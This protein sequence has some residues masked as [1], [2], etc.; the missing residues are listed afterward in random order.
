MRHRASSRDAGSDRRLLAAAGIAV[1]LIAIAVYAATWRELPF[2]DAFEVHGVFS[3]SNQLRPGNPVRRAGVEIGKVTGV[4]TGPEGTSVVTMEL[5]DPKH[6]RRNASLAIKP[7]L[8]FEGNFYVDVSAGT[9]A[10]PQ[11]EDGTTIPLERTSVPV[12]VDQVLSTLTEP[13]RS[14]LTGTVAEL[15]TG[16]GGAR[17]M[18]GSDEMR[19]AT[20]EL[21]AA[22]GSVEQTARAVQG[23]A[24]G[25]LHRAVGSTAD[26]TEQLGR[27]PNALADLV[28]DFDRV[29]GA[30]SS[31]TDSLS[32]SVRS[33]D[34]VLRIA[35]A[36]LREI[37][38]AL[39][40]LTRFA[41]D[42][43]PG[44]RAAPAAFDGTTGLLRQL[45]LASQPGE[46]ASFVRDLEPLTANLP[47]LQ[48]PLARGLD[49]L[50]KA[51]QC[52][53]RTILPALNTKL[54]DGPNS[55]DRPVWHDVLHLGAN[56]LGSSA[57]FDG[58][59]GTLRLGLAEGAN[60]L[61]E[62]IP[63]VG[64]LIGNGEFE[65]VN[66][67]WL[68]AGVEPEYRPDAWCK[69]QEVPNFGAR[70]RIGTPVNKR[71]IPKRVPTRA[72]T[73][74]RSEVLGLLSGDRADRRS[75][76]RMLLKELPERRG[77]KKPPR[78]TAKRP[79]ALPSNPRPSADDSKP[80]SG[81]P[82]PQ[83]PPRRPLGDIVGGLLGSPKTDGKPSPQAQG[84]EGAVA[85]L[86]DDL[87]GRGGKR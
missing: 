50:D 51:A 4:R 86:L 45:Q 79:A 76:L 31:D 70:S 68:G 59:G 83:D 5:E 41:E 23:T 22:L 35:P 63:G 85:G 34:E 47:A 32:A 49:L 44:L 9:P 6:L 15:A 8:F 80:Q 57:G 39:P 62:F 2:G 43:R 87:L 3:T 53:N 52:V 10:A 81:S 18:R 33:F 29:A 36:S 82:P 28:A 25:D 69:D 54:P 13:V 64:E 21:D 27:D 20:R 84:L 55:T 56:L 37:D 19:R 11:L 30:L 24:A 77:G 78:R 48:P 66:P 61:Q 71:V 75:L 1:V 67:I 7:R 26:F 42:L 12:Q 40:V 72:E 65:G 73:R 17:G 38:A 14:A 60:A 16:L 58:N 46:L 74:R